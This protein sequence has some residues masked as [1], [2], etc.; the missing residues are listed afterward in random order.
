MAHQ[1]IV[2]PSRREESP[3]EAARAAREEIRSTLAR[4]PMH[5]LALRAGILHCG[6]ME[7]QG[8]DVLLREV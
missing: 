6:S 2:I 8:Y 5:Q 4:S 3:D 7:R 1:A